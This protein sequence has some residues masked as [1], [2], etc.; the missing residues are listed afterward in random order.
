MGVYDRRY[1][2]IPQ[3]MSTAK[4]NDEQLAELRRVLAECGVAR[5]AKVVKCSPDTAETLW[6]GGR[7]SP[8]AAAR[9]GKRLDELRAERLARAS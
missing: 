9:I 2:P 4:L 1:D 6:S 8:P 3:K 7:V 5:G